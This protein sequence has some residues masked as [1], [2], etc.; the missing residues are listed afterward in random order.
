MKCAKINTH[1]EDI[2]S[3]YPAFFQ[4]PLSSNDANTM[5]KKPMARHNSPMVSINLILEPKKLTVFAHG[6]YFK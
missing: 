1:H 2:A 5:I 4:P 6:T 3:P